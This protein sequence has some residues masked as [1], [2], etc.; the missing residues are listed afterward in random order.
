MS[1][2]NKAILY[3]TIWSVLGQFGT[4]AVSLLS[5]IILARVLTPYE[6]GQVGIIM[7]FIIVANVLTESGLGGALVR[8]KDLTDDDYG[9]VFIVNLILSITCYLALVLSSNAISIYYKDNSLQNVLIV[10]GLILIINAFHIIQ[11]ARMIREFKFKQNYKYRFTAVCIASAIGIYLAYSGFGVWALVVMQLLTAL[12]NTTLL[13]FFEGAF[14]SFSFNKKS[15]KELYYFGFNTTLAS[16]L[17]TTFDN[18]YQLIL[19]RYFSINQV[20]L[21]Y[22]AKKL[23]EVPVGIINMTTQG[24]VFSSLSKIQDNSILFVKTYNKV[25][26]QFTIV[27]GLLTVL[28]YTYSESLVLLFY[29][30]KWLE[31]AFYMQLLAIASFFYMQEMFSRVIFKVYDQT[32]KILYLEIV[33][34]VI[35]S[36]IIVIGVVN[37][38]LL[39]LLY[40]LI[41]SCIISYLI[42][43]YYSRKVILGV[44]VNEILVILKVVLIS[45]ISIYISIILTEQLNIEGLYS[46]IVLPI[47]T[48]I[49][50]SLIHLF[51][52]TNIIT[53]YRMFYKIIKQRTI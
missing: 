22:Q 40:G 50:F 47:T 8:K 28:L 48:I 27:V 41:I 18:I 25:V 11:N 16:L 37:L 43:L 23:Q 42:N 53:D 5:N 24:V 3:G 34:K 39:T 32:H 31:A 2:L 52:V 51:E 33:K 29:G 9:T 45:I 10:L 13:W 20:G 44:A 19:G 7:F 38:S 12:F 14:L 26:L 21:F 1:Q 15:F 30:K 4:M 17:N 35:Q 36:V 46:F 6:F 49:Y